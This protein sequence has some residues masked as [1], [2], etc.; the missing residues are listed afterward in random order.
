MVSRQLCDNFVKTSDN[1][2]KTSD[3]F[4]KTSDNFVKIIYKNL[5]K[6]LVRFQDHPEM[7]SILMGL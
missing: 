2:V 5:R 6:A 3:N 7:G 1:F 4:V